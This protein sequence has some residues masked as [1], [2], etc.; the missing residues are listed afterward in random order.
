MKLIGFTATPWRMKDGALV[1]TRWWDKVVFNLCSK[2]S[3]VDMISNGYLCE[4]IPFVQ[5]L[6]YKVDG[7]KTTKESNN[8]KINTNE[9]DYIN[10]ILNNDNAL[11]SEVINTS[12]NDISPALTSFTKF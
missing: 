7:I 1:D 11:A 9:E 3:F 5:P 10:Q 4:L 6:E 12:L 8:S 2:N